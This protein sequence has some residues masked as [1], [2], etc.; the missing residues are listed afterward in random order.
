M[1]VY[2]PG[3]VLIYFIAF[4]HAI[5]FCVSVCPRGQSMHCCAPCLTELLTCVFCL[6]NVLDHWIQSWSFFLPPSSL[7]TSPPS[8]SSV[9]LLHSHGSLCFYNLSC[10]AFFRQMS[11]IVI[12]TASDRLP[13]SSM[14]IPQILLIRSISVLSL[15]VF[16]IMSLKN[17]ATITDT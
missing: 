6:F 15:L 14:I 5:I 16:A 2:C 8:L 1:H 11:A 4:R 17:R 3:V 7:L 12:D 13:L 10:T 9:F